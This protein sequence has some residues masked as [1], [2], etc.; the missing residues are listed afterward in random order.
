MSIP[1]ATDAL[2]VV[3]LVTAAWH[4]A[5]LLVG[6]GRRFK[7]PHCGLT[8]WFRGVS[9]DEAARLHHR[10]QDHIASHNTEGAQS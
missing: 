9:D 6:R 5:V 1:A 10:M 2:A 3:I 8:I 4:I 7:C